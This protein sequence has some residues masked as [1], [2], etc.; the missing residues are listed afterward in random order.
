MVEA[1]QP[2]RESIADRILEQAKTEFGNIQKRLLETKNALSQNTFAVEEGEGENKTKK[3]SDI[4]P[5]DPYNPSEH[6]KRIKDRKRERE[7]G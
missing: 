1:L 5:S 7:G 3:I 6:I 2:Q 4:K